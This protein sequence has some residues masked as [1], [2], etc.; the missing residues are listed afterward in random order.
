VNVG[1]GYVGWVHGSGISVQGDTGDLLV[2]DSP[3][4]KKR[5]LKE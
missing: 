4:L 1:K 5:G 3:V 2:F